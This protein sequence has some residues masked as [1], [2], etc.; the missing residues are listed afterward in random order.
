M[1]VVG[2]A[3]PEDLR[4]PDQ[5]HSERA[6]LLARKVARKSKT[7]M[8]RRQTQLTVRPSE[9]ERPSRI[10]EIRPPEA[11]IIRGRRVR[12][13]NQRQLQHWSIQAEHTDAGFGQRQ[14]CYEPDNDRERSHQNYSV[15]PRP[16][17]PLQDSKYLLKPAA[18]RAAARS[19][20]ASTST[21]SV[22]A[23]PSGWSGRPATPP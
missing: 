20:A 6:R 18:P 5:G 9:V 2:D 23:A 15:F 11:R 1:F 17:R 19:L 21:G 13:A 8:V 4:V 12:G 14:P 7:L 16:V 10:R 3:E 22:R